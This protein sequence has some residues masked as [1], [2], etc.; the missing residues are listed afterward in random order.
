VG[1]NNWIITTY[2]IIQEYEGKDF[3]NSLDITTWEPQFFFIACIHL[4]ATEST[5][6]FGTVSAIRSVNRKLHRVSDKGPARRFGLR[7]HPLAPSSIVITVGIR[8]HLS[9][10]NRCTH[11]LPS[12]SLAPTLVMPGEEMNQK[13]QNKTSD[14]RQMRG[15]LGRT[16]GRWRL[17]V[18]QFEAIMIPDHIRIQ[19]SRRRRSIPGMTYSRYIR[20]FPW[21]PVWKV[22]DL[23]WIYS[24]FR[25]RK[26]D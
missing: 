22:L 8:M 19:T 4:R 13:I 10:P 26:I 2:G 17:R 12:Q 1:Q 18:N 7:S 23:N 6:V 20:C 21:M 16:T 3:L 5:A 9:R 24:S 11:I 14:L 15:G 25:R